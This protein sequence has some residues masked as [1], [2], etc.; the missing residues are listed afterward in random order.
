MSK[1]NHDNFDEYFGKCTDCEASRE[2]IIAEEFRVELEQVYSKMLEALGI[3]TGDISPEQL[4]D[5]EQKEIA[6]AN[7]VSKW[8]DNRYE[9]GE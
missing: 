7:S 3:E 5:I 8:L 6:L 9:S 2:T 1:C 4:V